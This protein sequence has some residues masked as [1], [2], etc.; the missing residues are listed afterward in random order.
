MIPACGTIGKFLKITPW[1]DSS[2]DSILT[3][4]TWL[5]SQEGNSLIILVWRDDSNVQH[6]WQQG[7]A[8]H[9]CKFLLILFMLCLY[10]CCYDTKIRNQDHNSPGY[11]SV[12][13]LFF[14]FKKHNNFLA[15]TSKNIFN[16]KRK[17]LK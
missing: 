2:I 17:G 14:P 16:T 8:S 3:I 9:S 15:F 13:F 1:V 10:Y 5:I 11:Y 12:S 7:L 6:H 4:S